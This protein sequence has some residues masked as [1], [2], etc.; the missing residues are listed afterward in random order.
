MHATKC[1]H[2]DNPHQERK[3]YKYHNKSE[4][5]FASK[6]VSSAHATGVSTSFSQGK[7]R[8]SE[9]RIH[10]RRCS[11]SR[12]TP[13]GANS[14]DQIREYER[15]NDYKRY[16]HLLESLWRKNEKVHKKPVTPD[17]ILQEIDRFKHKKENKQ[18][19]HKHQNWLET[20][21]L[22]FLQQFYHL[23]TE[24]GGKTLTAQYVIDA[25]GNNKEL[26][27]YR[28]RDYSCFL[29]ECFKNPI[30]P[31]KV[32]G[33]I[34]TA[35]KIIQYLPSDKQN[36]CKLAEIKRYLCMN[37]IL[38]DG[39]PVTAREVINLFDMSSYVKAPL[40]KGLFLQEAYFKSLLLDGKKITPDMVCEVFEGLN[41]EEGLRAKELFMKKLHARK[42]PFSDKI[43]TSEH[44]CEAFSVLNAEMS[45]HPIPGFQHRQ[46]NQSQHKSLATCASK[47][48]TGAS[49]MLSQK[50][51][52]KILEEYFRSGKRWNNCVVTTADVLA[53]YERTKQL[54]NYLNFLQSLWRNKT[55]HKR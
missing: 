6:G 43:V 22:G 11:E 49:M 3:P 23:K 55:A 18:D 32:D 38:L 46:P 16:F 14:D 19:G 44:D 8:E 54:I 52:P 4:G 13:V 39:K 50:G 2:G 12:D 5:T 7:G 33:G 26:K 24:V 25:Y 29:F 48:V 27:P 42:I 28:A 21:R 37:D 30:E 41:I 31:A 40:F 34:I 10:K 47:D 53:F 35:E 17:Y 20:I 15:S 36:L 9:K 45:P 51:D 1:G